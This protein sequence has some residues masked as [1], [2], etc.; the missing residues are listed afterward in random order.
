MNYGFTLKIR[1]FV[2]TFACL[3]SF[4]I[5]PATYATLAPR[6]TLTVNI[7]T[8]LPGTGGSVTVS[9]LGMFTA[10]NP[11]TLTATGTNQSVSCKHEYAGTT[12]ITVSYAALPGSALKAPSCFPANACSCSG[13]TCTVTVDNENGSIGLRFFRPQFTFV[14]ETSST[15]TG[16]VN[17]N[18]PL[19]ATAP[20][21]SR[22]GFFD[23]GTKIE[24]TPVPGT[25]F[26]SS[27]GGA[28]SGNGVCS[29][30]LTDDKAVRGTFKIPSLQI[31]KTGKAASESRVAGGSLIDCGNTC[32]EPIA[33]GT[34]V[35][36]KA[37]AGTGSVFKGWT[38]CNAVGPTDCTFKITNHT[39]VTAEFVYQ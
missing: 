22:F 32:S 29:V 28:C 31:S 21:D 18:V 14:R 34:V 20:S 4:A 23:A 39:T 27:W 19:N 12:T 37:I 5:C 15:G 3:F 16:T 30:V 38:G 1:P 13:S 26:F 2:F 33:F 10:T 24:L 8:N 17:A 35:T 7:S 9:P 11:C 36:L 25:G 6:K